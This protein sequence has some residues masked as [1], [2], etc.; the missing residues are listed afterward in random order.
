WGIL[1]NRLLLPAAARHWTTAQLQSVLLHELAHIK[2]RDTLAQLLTQFACALHWFNP[3]VWFAAWR[4]GVERERACDDLVLVSGVRPS[5]YAAHLLEI[6]TELSPARWIQSCGLAMARKSSL[7]V[8]LVAVLS[9]NLNR[10]RV[11]VVIAA[12]ALTVAIGISVPLAMLRAAEQK[13]VETAKPAMPDPKPKHEYAQALFTKWKANARTDGKI[14]GA[15]IGH[16]AREIDNF[17]KQSPQDPKAPQLA[18]LRPRLDATHD[19]TQA[20]VVALLDDITAISTAPVSWAD[21]PLEFDQMRSLKL[22]EPLPEQL[23]TAAWGVPEENGL[24]AAWLLEPRAKQY[25]LGT[26]LKARVLF[27]NTGPKPVIFRT[28]VWHQMDQHT[29]R[30]AQDT[31]IKVSGTWYTGITP[32]AVYRLA[33]GE[34][35]AVTGHGIAIGS[36][37][38]EEEYSTGSVGA[39]IEA[40]VRDVVRLSHSV[41]TTYGGWTRPN[42]PKD[43]VELWKQSIAE[44]VGREAPLPSAAADREQLIR[45]V[46]LDLF[47]E[48]PSAEEVT[49]FITDNAPDSLAKLT[50]RLQAKP[51]IKLFSGKLPTGET[52]FRVTSA[53]PEATKKPRGAKSPGRYVLADQVHLLVSQTTTST[54]RTNKA[55]IAFLSP[56]PK[57]ASE[58]Q[59]HEIAL[60][61]GLDSWGAV[62]ERGTGELWVMQKNLV[63]KYDFRNPTEVRETRFESGSI[64]NVPEHLRAAMLLV[65]HQTDSPTQQKQPQQESQQP[66]S[67]EKTP[68]GAEKIQPKDEEA[69]ALFKMWKRHARKNGNIPGGLVARLRSKVE[70]FVRNNSGDA[71]GDPYAKK[72]APLIKRIDGS[73]DWTPTEVVSLLDDIAGAHTIPL[74]TTLHESMQRN[75]KMGAP[76]PPELSSA[77]WGEALPNGLRMAWFLEPNAKQY[78]LGTALNSRILLHNSGQ[79]A[80]VFRTQNWHQSGNHQAHDAQGV[81]INVSS[82]HWTTLGQLVPFR[83]APGEFVEVVGAGIGVGKNNHDEDWQGTRVGSWIEAQVGDVVTFTPDAVPLDDRNDAPPSKRESDWWQ[84]FITER[85]NLE[86]PLPAAV[87]ERAQLFDRVMRDLFGTTPSAEEMTAFCTDTAPDALDSLVKRLVRRPGIASFSGLLTSGTRKFRVLPVDPDAA[88]KPRTA[89]NP[90]RYTLGEHIRLVVSRRPDGQRTVNEAKIMFFSADPTKPAPGGPHKV[91]L[92]DGY[93]TWAAAW[94]RGSN[95]LW[96]LQKGNVRSYDFTNPAQVKETTLEEPVNLEQVPMSILSSMRAILNDSG[97]PKPMPEPK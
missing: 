21:L 88:K 28:E 68:S 78:R 76:L 20:D 41:D 44:R 49:A 71:A 97:T 89:H 36:G 77:P 92:P 64:L 48:P 80:V 14:P 1:K 87:D 85:L 42:D 62:W 60:P 26:V 54:E 45:R 52:K 67:R 83:L 37:K 23:M 15:L 34:Y 25:A 13:R 72:M 11:S 19:W 61:D 31:A 66:D 59:P 17:L 58:F 29:A 24:R 94:E 32:T 91:Q 3:L 70:E 95:V 74:E 90:G 46:T 27:H 56:D 7:E 6:V 86:L 55:V 9:H 69:Q 22:G 79:T 18:A 75:F 82:T 2:R 73:R 40:K 8:R 63:R 12:I 47:G 33:P 10:R 50:A 35:C 30:D 16:V 84:R 93:N 57:V 51:H 81:N 96:V 38:Y 5:A 43:P 39:V 53:D 4:L 65:F